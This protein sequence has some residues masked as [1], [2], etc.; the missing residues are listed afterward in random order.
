MRR[1]FRMMF[2]EQVMDVHPV[3]IFI[4]VKDICAEIRGW[5]VIICIFTSVQR[6]IRKCVVFLD[7]IC[8]GFRSKIVCTGYFGLFDLPFLLFL[9]IDVS[10]PTKLAQTKNLIVKWSWGRIESGTCGTISDISENFSAMRFRIE[11]NKLHVWSCIYH[12]KCFSDMNFMES[13]D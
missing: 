9:T 5:F 8:A 12:F 7:R 3:F 11:V 6:K 10:W 2:K 1:D 4:Q 13:S